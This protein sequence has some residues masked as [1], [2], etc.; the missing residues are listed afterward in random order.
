MPHYVHNSS[1]VQFGQTYIYFFQLPNS[2][3]RKVN[4]TTSCEKLPFKI[5]LKLAIFS[6]FFKTLQVKK[7]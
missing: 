1:T 4:G 3:N 6:Q 7:Q 2:H 5:I